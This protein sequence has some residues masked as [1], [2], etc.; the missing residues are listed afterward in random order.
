MNSYKNKLNQIRVVLGMTVQLASEE[1][2]DGTIVEAEAFEEGYPL[3][4]KS[5]AGDTPDRKSVV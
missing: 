5:D 2:V 4:V 3:F 1:L